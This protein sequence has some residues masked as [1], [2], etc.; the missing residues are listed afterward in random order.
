MLNKII[1]VMC[2]GPFQ[3]QDNH[4]ITFDF[5]VFITP[6]IIIT[7]GSDDGGDTF[8]VLSRLLI[9]LFIFVVYV[10]RMV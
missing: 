7:H 1:H 3:V 4:L 9:P 2:L 10:F 5:V 6:I 8:H